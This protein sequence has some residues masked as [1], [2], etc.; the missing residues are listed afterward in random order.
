MAKKKTPSDKA[1][2]VIGIGGSAGAIEPV[3]DIAESL[4]N[5]T[6]MAYI[7]LQHQNPDF[8]SKLSDLLAKRS[9]LS[10]VPVE[11][12]MSIEADF[13]YVVP[14]GKEMT[15]ANGNFKLLQRPE[16][17]D[18][19]P[20][21]R[22]LT[23]LAEEYK[24]FAVGII[25]SG[26]DSDGAQGVK[27][28]KAMGGLTFA[29]DESALFQ[30]MPKSAIAEGAI[31]LVLSPK[32]IAEELKSLARQ[33]EAYY[34]AIQDQNGEGISNKDKDLITILQL[35]Q[36]A[37]NVNFEQYKMSTIK[38]RIIRRMVLHRLNTLQ[39]YINYIRTNP[40]EIHLL[41]QDLL[42]NV[43]TFF[44]DPELS[45]YLK[46]TLLP[47]IIKSKRHNEAIRI[48]VP[49]CSTGQ[50]VY[51]LAILLIEV[52]GEQYAHL[53]IQI[54]ATDLSEAAINKARLGVYSKADVE[55]VSPKRL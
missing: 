21:N 20:I 14:P 17:Y 16:N 50:E 34:N 30:S 7:Y 4:P 3:L 55:E 49:A 24:E 37:V 23:S 2:P 42:I 32:D 43:T 19:M 26:A 35:L 31:D 9:R 51:S 8:D 13:F 39:E 25:L 12:D 54:F 46:T 44:R 18:H 1:F 40:P 48:W 38:R 29:Q 47:E 22:F 10:I 52:L 15:V 11:N 6:G 27:A 45:D 36:K 5:D 28:I 41:F 33:K 53:P